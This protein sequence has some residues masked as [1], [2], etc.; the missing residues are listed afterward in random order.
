VRLA[1]INRE[2]ARLVLVVL[3]SAL[4]GCGPA[5]D[6]TL[7]ETFEQVY[8]IEP[9]AKVTITNGDG[10][11]F[12]YGSNVNEMRV[13]AIKRAY[14]RQRLK[15]IAIDVSIQPGSVSINTRFPARP[16]WALSDSSGT[17]D[18]TIVLPATA[19]ISELNLNAGEVLVDG[20]R[21]R[22]V[23]ARLGRGQMF[24]HNCFSNVAFTVGSGTLTL[25]YEWWEPGKFSIQAN[26]ARGNAWAFLPSDIDLHLIAETG[27]GKID[28]DFG[29]SAE[30][31]TKDITKTD[32][33]IRG[34]GEAALRIHATEGNVKIVEENP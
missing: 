19:N 6:R 8:T 20:M 24:G 29:E 30:R 5:T 4:A 2:G 10:V 21:G 1:A 7:E 26:I 16:K 31:G 3:L 27:D 28:N 32:M 34:G 18:Y 11:V 17:V 13:E 23:Q 14:T 15:Q 25:A 22:A 12:V 9:T 33:L